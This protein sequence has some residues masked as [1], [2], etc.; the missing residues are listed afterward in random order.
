MHE[1]L[2]ALAFALL[3]AGNNI[4]ARIAIMAM[5]TSNSINVKPLG[6]VLV[7]F[8]ELE[9]SKCIFL[10]FLASGYMKDVAFIVFS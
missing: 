8:I 6:W 5:T 9:N 10:P 4:A 2:C 1:I 3:K 7:C